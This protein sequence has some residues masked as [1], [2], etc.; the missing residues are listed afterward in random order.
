MLNPEEIEIIHEYAEKDSF[1]LALKLKKYPGIDSQKI[2]QQIHSRKKIKEK[3]P[4]WWKQK[5]L[6]FPTGISLEQGSS[7]ATARFKGTLIQGNILDI[8]GG[9]GVDSWG[10]SLN[11]ENKITACEHHSE[12]ILISKLNHQRLN[13]KVQWI[14]TN[15]LSFALKNY[16][17]FDWIYADPDRRG[18]TGQK[19]YKLADCEPNIIELIERLPQQNFLFKLSPIADISQTLKELNGADKIWVVVFNGEVKELV[20]QKTRN[21]T[22]DPP[23]EILEIDKNFTIKTIFSGKK[24]LEKNAEIPISRI[25]NFLYEPH[26]G[27]LKAGFFKSIVEKDLKKLAV[28]THLYTSMEFLENFP[29]KKFE[30]IYSGKFE[31]GIINKIVGDKIEI[32]ERNFPLKPIEIYQKLKLRAGGENFLYCYRN[33]ENNLEMA[34]CKRR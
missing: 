32:I 19:L 26:I 4:T 30:V 3:I 20:I 18:K 34:I 1:D 9:M 13:T 25:G 31:K 27:I 24:S 10:F 28:N 22:D 7:E 2:S 11:P 16:Q 12:L 14:E 6:F 8:T 21:S 5:D 33:S 23:I 29:G 17:N 15:G